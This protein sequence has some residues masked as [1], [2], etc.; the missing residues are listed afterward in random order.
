MRRTMQEVYP[1]EFGP[2]H[3]LGSDPV[4]PAI[5]DDEVDC[6]WTNRSANHTS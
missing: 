4:R 6:A 1:W 3:V 2:D 5:D